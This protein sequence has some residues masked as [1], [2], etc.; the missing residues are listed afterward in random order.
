MDEGEIEFSEDPLR[1]DQVT[2]QSQL[3]DCYFKIETRPEQIVLEESLVRS[4]SSVS[5]AFEA[6]RARERR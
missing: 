5:L 3:D 4:R 6:Y 2:K 1:V